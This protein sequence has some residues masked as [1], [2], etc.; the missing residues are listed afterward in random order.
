[1]RVQCPC[2]TL[3]KHTGNPSSNFA[4][5]LPSQDTDSY[6]DAIETAIQ[7]HEKDVAA[8]YVIYDT[9]G[10]FR[11]MCQCPTCGR[12]FIEDERF[13]VFEFIPVDPEVRKDLLGGGRTKRS[14]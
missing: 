2:G 1:M 3:L 14:T 7:K 4:D 12:V 10:F 5:L 9:T 11:R 13:Q 6:C 8:E